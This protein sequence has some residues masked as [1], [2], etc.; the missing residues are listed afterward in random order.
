MRDFPGKNSIFQEILSK[1]VGEWPRYLAHFGCS[2]LDI[3]LSAENPE[4]Q[5]CMSMYYVQR[6]LSVLVWC[7]PVQY[8]PRYSRKTPKGG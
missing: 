6:N 1:L 3:C 5:R 2:V 7:T 4:I 8:W